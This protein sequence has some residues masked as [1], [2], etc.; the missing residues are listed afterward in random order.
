MKK[1]LIF[2]AVAAGTYS[3]RKPEDRTCWKFTGKEV[4]V[5]YPL[6][7]FHLMTL[8]SHMAFELIQDSLNKIEITGGENLVNLIDFSVKDG[9]LEIKNRNKCSFLR[10]AKKELLVRIHLTKIQNIHYEGSEYLKSVGQIKSDYFTLQIRDGA[11]PVSLNLKSVFIDADIS[12]GWGDYTLTGE[13]QSARLSARSNGY[14]DAFGLNI[15]DSVYVASDT[16]GTIKVRA[17]GIPFYGYAKNSGDVWYVGHPTVT[18]VILTGE[19]ELVD[20]N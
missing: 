1:L 16:P 4:T 10:N 17:D 8:H 6:D 9:M 18:N 20:R 7:D 3:C 12:H 19:G 11:G 15:T 13:T 2:A 5:E 14:F